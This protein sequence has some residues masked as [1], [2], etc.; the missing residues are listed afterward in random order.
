ME[1][2]QRDGW[3]LISI[4]EALDTRSAV[5]EFTAT[6]LAGLAQMERKLIAER[7]SRVVDARLLHDTEEI[8]IGIFQHDEVGVGTIPPRISL[9][10][11]FD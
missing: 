11:K 5:G 1:A 8:A 6:I 10:T 4:T 2:A 7:T 3:R 9:R